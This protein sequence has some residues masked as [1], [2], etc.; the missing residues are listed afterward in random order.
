MYDLH[1]GRTEE[2]G[3]FI[4]I[5]SGTGRADIFDVP[6]TK[7]RLWG[8]KLTDGESVRLCNELQDLLKRGTEDAR[9]ISNSQEQVEPLQAMPTPQ[10]TPQRRID[11]GQDSL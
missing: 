6:S 8:I 5:P 3:L 4:A 7:H 9:Q 10:D 2:G 11:A 1:V